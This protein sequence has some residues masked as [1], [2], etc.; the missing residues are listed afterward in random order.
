M[1]K[2]GPKNVRPGERNYCIRPLAAS[3]FVRVRGKR[4]NDANRICR[5]RVPLLALMTDRASGRAN[6]VLNVPTYGGLARKGTLGIRGRGLFKA[7]FVSQGTEWPLKMYVLSDSWTSC[8]IGRLKLSHF[9]SRSQL[10]ARSSPSVVIDW[11]TGRPTELPIALTEIAPASSDANKNSTFSQM[12]SSG[13]LRYLRGR[14]SGS[15]C[16]KL[17]LYVC[18]RASH[19]LTSSQTFL[20][21]RTQ[22]S[23]P[24]PLPSPIQ[25]WKAN[26]LLN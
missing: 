7:Q 21:S 26:S 12:F 14:K 9:F 6:R 20:N 13:S 8:N 2:L 19:N 5:R 11:L 17:L 23:S 25:T 3:A 15:K 22:S 10:F 1:Q 4:L 24:L 18:H 16:L